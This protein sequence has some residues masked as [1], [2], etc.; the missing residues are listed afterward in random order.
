MK[1]DLKRVYRHHGIKY[2]AFP[3][4]VLLML[5][6]LADQRLGGY[7]DHREE[8]SDLAI[9]LESNRNI[10]DLHGK[11]QRNHDELSATF[12]SLEPKIF[13]APDIAQSVNAMQEQVRAL[14]QSLYFDNVEFFDF[15]DTTKGGVSRISM[16]AR[17]NGVPQQLPRLEAALAQAPKL[18]SVDALEIKVIDDP[19]RGG[20]QLAV[21]ARFAGLHM[22]Q[23][24]VP[25]PA[26]ASKNTEVKP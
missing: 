25:I 24:P 16:S 23:I 22:K 10:L 20:Q 3:A 14:L 8:A 9:R 5:A 2:F 15:S 17:F 11:V 26:N 18:L 1:R 4:V 12:V 7:M 6:A 21:M 13:V 19:Q